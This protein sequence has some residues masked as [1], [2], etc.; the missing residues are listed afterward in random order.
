MTRRSIIIALFTCTFRFNK[1]V[2]LFLFPCAE[3]ISDS[4]C[5]LLSQDQKQTTAFIFKAAFKGISKETIVIGISAVE[6]EHKKN[7]YKLHR[8]LKDSF[9][10][11]VRVSGIRADL[12]YKSPS[13][14][15]FCIMFEGF[16]IDQQEIRAKF[17]FAKR[18]EREIRRGKSLQ[19][20][21]HESKSR[22]LKIG[23]R[24][25]SRV[26]P[27]SAIDA[28]CRFTEKSYSRLTL[29]SHSQGVVQLDKVTL[30]TN[31][32]CSL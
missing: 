25:T 8:F 32:S 16:D 29:T 31:D 17:A 13:L 9:T 18:S 7:S 4:C 19:T 30:D 5:I 28:S 23:T 22:K 1:V 10:R 14:Q 2:L 20:A 11:S 27:D 6:K 12:S 26:F 21:E 3:W 15:E 24:E